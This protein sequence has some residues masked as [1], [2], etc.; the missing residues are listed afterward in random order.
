MIDERFHRLDQVVPNGLP[1]A[2][3][4]LDDCVGNTSELASSPGAKEV[5]VLGPY[6]KWANGIL[7]KVVVQFDPTIAEV[8]VEALPLVECVG[9]GLTHEAFGEVPTLDFF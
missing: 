8:G 5:V 4:I 3:A 6:F 7:T 1:M 2:L 9:D